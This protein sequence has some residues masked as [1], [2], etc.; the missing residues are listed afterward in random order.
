[1]L[2]NRLC[3]TPHT[4][5]SIDK[6]YFRSLRTTHSSPML[7]EGTRPEVVRDNMGRANI[8]VT[9]VVYC[10]SWWEEPSKELTDTWL[11]VFAIALSVQN[12]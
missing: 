3:R 10:K 6:G 5:D 8:D 4:A 9:H 12:A 2:A 11:P 7:R 1:M